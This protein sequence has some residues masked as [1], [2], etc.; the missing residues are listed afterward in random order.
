MS[1]V[2]GTKE[3]V[4]FYIHYI[5]AIAEYK[6]HCYDATSWAYEILTKKPT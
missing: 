6:I 3:V 4:L 1:Y 2:K 5:H